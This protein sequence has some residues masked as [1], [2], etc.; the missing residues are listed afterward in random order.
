[1]TLNKLTSYAD[2]DLWR[3]CRAFNADFSIDKLEFAE[4]AVWE[5]LFH[6]YMRNPG[7]EAEEN[8]LREI[9]RRWDKDGNEIEGIPLPK[10]PF[11]DPQ[12]ALGDQIIE[13]APQQ[14]C[15]KI[16]RQVLTFI[17]YV[18]IKTAEAGKYHEI[19]PL[20]DD[21][22]I[23]LCDLFYEL[24]VPVGELT[25]FCRGQ[26]LKAKISRQEYH[27][28]QLKEKKRIYWYLSGYS[29]C[30]EPIEGMNL[31]TQIYDVYPGLIAEI[32]FACNTEHKI[33]RDQ[34]SW[35]GEELENVIADFFK[36]NPHIT[37]I[38]F[39]QSDNSLYRATPDNPFSSKAAKATV[40]YKAGEI[41]E[42]EWLASFLSTPE[43][44]DPQD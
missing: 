28:E 15:I 31:L 22:D 17:D 3:V 7:P 27:A 19:Y 10:K 13:K 23:A 34:P 11:I 4:H 30:S 26:L 43:Q 42:E 32:N 37:S 33:Y 41:S 12:K 38:D 8:F 20:S 6:E 16:L 21:E 14:D 39:R 29:S 18:P 44:K 9:N 25:Q 5:A 40:K 35:T 24:R 36:L 2:F 1:M